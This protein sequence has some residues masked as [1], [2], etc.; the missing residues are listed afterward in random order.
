[1]SIVYDVRDTWR[2]LVRSPNFTIPV[3][4]SLAFAIGANVAAFSLINT[5]ILK[6]LP[7]SEPDRL[8]QVA[9]LGDRGRSDGAN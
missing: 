3:L 7:V 8:F 1:M 6:P 5:L 4:L 9:Y 2:S